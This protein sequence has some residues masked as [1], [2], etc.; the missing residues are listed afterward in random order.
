MNKNCDHLLLSVFKG[1]V[2]RLCLFV[3]LLLSVFKGNVQRL[4]LLTIVF[5]CSKGSS[6]SKENE[7]NPMFTHDGFSRGNLIAT[8]KRHNSLVKSLSL[9]IHMHT[10]NQWCVCN[11]CVY[12]K[13]M[14]A[15]IICFT[16]MTKLNKN[17]KLHN[18]RKTM[19]LCSS[20]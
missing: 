8:T 14:R 16:I 10:V 11:V 17:G 6:K 4:C 2:Q 7:V 3:Y 9:F 1:N 19:E 5:I 18:E 12:I 15:V 13:H 20:K